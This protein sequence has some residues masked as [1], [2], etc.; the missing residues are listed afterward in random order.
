M[1]DLEYQ[2][3]RYADHLETVA[4]PLSIDD[5]ERSDPGSHR[6]KRLIVA[7][8]VM[9][10][11]ALV[12][13]LE[14]RADDE[15]EVAAGTSVS[16]AVV[17]Y[18]DGDSL[19]RRDVGTGEERRT[20]LDGTQSV[21]DLLVVGD[22]LFAL[23]EPAG[24]DGNYTRQ[25]LAVDANLTG[26]P[27]P[28]GPSM[29]LLASVEP[30]RVWLWD[31]DWD[32]ELREVDT[33]GNVTA[34]TPTPSGFPFAAIPGGFVIDLPL[35]HLGAWNTD[36]ATSSPLA[37]AA[38]ERFQQQ[39]LATHDTTMV[40]LGC[41]NDAVV[42]CGLHIT[43]AGGRRRTIEVDWTI[44]LRAAGAISSDGDTL[45]LVTGEAASNV[46]LIDLREGRILTEQTLLTDERLAP[47]GVGDQPELAWVAEDECV[48][49]TSVAGIS[50]RCRDDGSTAS[51]LTPA[52]TPIAG[53]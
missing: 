34:T 33:T 35:Y 2:L 44:D 36:N 9:I 18:A 25:A 43:D 52:R 30:G 20:R 53:F 6:P 27:R 45:A 51:I 46:F 39:F 37:A 14:L 26:T 32:G 11:V 49:W 5:I 23:T 31:G 10:T 7:A 42:P 28:L 13:A 24:H 40:W 16:A 3:R 4:P 12:A 48:A 15:S 50:L 41:D 1:P 17:F 29:V 19:V 38:D 47:A 21:L 8:A 22:T